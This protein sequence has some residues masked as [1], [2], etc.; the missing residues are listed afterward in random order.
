MSFP[1]SSGR[2]ALRF[3]LAGLV[4]VTSSACG[5]SA[6]QVESPDA[7]YQEAVSEHADEDYDIAVQKYRQ[8]LDHYPLDPRAQ[9]IELRI[10]HAHLANESH[11][12]AIAAFSDF[13]RMHP[14]S[15]HVPEVEYRIGQAYVEQIDSIDRDLGAARNAHA[16]L[17]SILARY[18]NSEFNKDA[19]D[20]LHYVREHLAGRELYI[21]EYYFDRDHYPAGWVRTATV[22]ALFPET[23]T[24]ALAAERLA[25]AASD[26]GDEETAKLATAAAAELEEADREEDGAPGARRSPGPALLALRAHLQTLPPPD[27]EDEGA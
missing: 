24:A 6:M 12:E 13:Q 9:E 23:T 26:V 18:P 17:Q 7:L 16:R 27:S 11:P 10:A 15:P 25:S 21:A 3:L 5:K 1:C 8:L 22:L 4:V 14:T 19:I 2:V 20:Q